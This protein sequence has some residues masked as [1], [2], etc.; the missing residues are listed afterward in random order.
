M[1]SLKDG[2]GVQ[3]F[4]RKTE[5]LNCQCELFTEWAHVDLSPRFVDHEQSNQQWPQIYD[6][7]QMSP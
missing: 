1:L 3:T 7:K 6:T 4:A 5:A 2:A